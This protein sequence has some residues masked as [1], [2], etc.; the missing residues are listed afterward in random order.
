MLEGIAPNVCATVGGASHGPIQRWRVVD[1]L[2]RLALSREP[3]PLRY[4]RALPRGRRSPHAGP[5]RIGRPPRAPHDRQHRRA[6]PHRPPARRRRHGRG[7]RRPR[8]PARAA[9]GAQALAPRPGR[10]GAARPLLARGP[11]RGRTQ[12][13]QRLP[14]LRDRRGPRA[15]VH[16]H[17]AARGRDAGRPPDPRPARAPRIAARRP[18]AAGRAARG[19]PAR[20]RAPRRQA[21]ERVPARATAGSSCST[22]GW[23]CRCR[24]TRSRRAPP[25]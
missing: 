25:G 13:S 15:P 21:L 14:P 3:A 18:R 1:G 9:G 20:L 7:L 11:R 12:P 16:H 19:S 10:R 8:P 23:C 24:R 17:G 22:S 6:L 2:T 5:P 4:S